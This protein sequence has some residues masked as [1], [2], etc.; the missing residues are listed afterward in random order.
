[1]QAQRMAHAVG[2]MTAPVD[3]RM[4]RMVP[5]AMGGVGA[6]GGADAG[7]WDVAGAAAYGEGLRSMAGRNQLERNL[8]NE[9][10]NVHGALHNALMG[11]PANPFEAMVGGSHPTAGQV[12]SYSRAFPSATGGAAT[13]ASPMRPG[14]L[15]AGLSAAGGPGGARM[16]ALPGQTPSVVVPRPPAMAPLQMAATEMDRRMP[17][18]L[19]A[20]AGPAG[21][22]PGGRPPVQV[23]GAVE[24][25]SVQEPNRQVAVPR[26]PQL[27]AN[28]TPEMIRALPTMARFRPG[29]GRVG[30]GETPL[31]PVGGTTLPGLG[32]A[33]ADPVGEFMAAQTALAD[34]YRR[35]GNEGMSLAIM[36]DAREKAIGMR[37]ELEAA[38][39][40]RR[41]Q[42]AETNHLNALA[43]STRKSFQG[44]PEEEALHAAFKSGALDWNTYQGQLAIVRARRNNPVTGATTP[45]AG[46]SPT[47][48]STAS[49]TAA[50]LPAA[51]AMDRLRQSMPDVDAILGS[52]WEVGGPLNTNRPAYDAVHRAIERG[53][54]IGPGHEGEPLDSDFRAV[55]RGR[56]GDDYW[57]QAQQDPGVGTR[58]LGYPVGGWNNPIA[59]ALSGYSPFPGGYQHA[60]D[61][62]RKA[63]QFARWARSGAPIAVPKPPAVVVPK[64]RLDH[65]GTEI[66]R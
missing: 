28:I 54:P 63:L 20:F 50:P 45:S 11:K 3:P 66:R 33:P 30:G 15:L 12:A 46:L 25:G 2:P 47:G 23:H 22:A 44:S 43:E 49:G 64:P 29:V 39:V 19:D 7:L 41:R 52:N 51:L 26:P 17:A 1:M 53:Y 9:Q 58:G 21:A 35:Q 61:D 10:A 16:A 56:L 55:L 38:A 42:E 36:S 37:Q 24:L 60:E 14:G 18:G 31:V 48:A 65:W 59:R 32:G 57:S 40:G 27:A 6:M 4:A 8:E 62:D 13:P 34:H 5:R